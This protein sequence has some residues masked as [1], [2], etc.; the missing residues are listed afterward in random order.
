MIPFLAT[1][2]AS[3]DAEHEDNATAK[4]PPSNETVVGGAYESSNKT[5]EVVGEDVGNATA[6]T[7][8]GLYWRALRYMFGPCMGAG[9]TDGAQ[10]KQAMVAINVSETVPVVE[11][12][13]GEE[14]NI[15][16]SPPPSPP[17]SFLSMDVVA[18]ACSRW[19]MPRFKCCPLPPSSFLSMD[20]VALAC[21]RWLM[22]RWKCWPSRFR[23]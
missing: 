23:Q 20:V 16:I 4:A 13:T 12:L 8:P 11:E 3:S 14:V 22:P 2:S 21:S 19:L 10:G 17:S 18:L 1:H 6:P 15:D 5:A 7:Q 9:G